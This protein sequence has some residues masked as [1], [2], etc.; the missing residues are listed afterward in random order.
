MPSRAATIGPMTKS[1]VLAAVRARMLLDSGRARDI[2][3][4]AGVT[5]E[6]VARQSV[7]RGRRLLIGRV[8]YDVLVP[9]WRLGT[10]NCLTS[11][12]I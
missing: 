2:R 9:N 7:R 6:D 10:V 3:K 4:R 8:V 5:R 1:E 12:S 11:L